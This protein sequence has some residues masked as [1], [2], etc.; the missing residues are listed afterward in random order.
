MAVRYTGAEKHNDV[1]TA[2]V[3]L[4]EVE[5][6]GAIER[7]R[8]RVGVTPRKAVRTRNGKRPL[9]WVRAFL[10]H[11]RHGDAPGEPRVTRERLMHFLVHRRPRLS[12]TVGAC[13][14]RL[15]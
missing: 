7:N 4:A 15:G 13:V 3:G 6:A 10:A 9:G 2:D 11:L 1:I 5:L 12:V 8:V 14:E